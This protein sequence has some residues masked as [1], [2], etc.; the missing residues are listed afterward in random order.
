MYNTAVGAKKRQRMRTGACHDSLIYQSDN[1][2]LFQHDIV[3]GMHDLYASANAIHSELSWHNGYKIF[4]KSTIAENT[5]FDGYIKGILIV[6]NALKVP[7]FLMVGPRLIKSLNPDWI[8]PTHFHAHNGADSL[9]A[10]YNHPQDISFNDETE[11]I[12]HMAKNYDTV[13]DFCCGY[14]NILNPVIVQEKKA[15]LSDINTDCIHYIRDKYHM[16]PIQGGTN[17]TT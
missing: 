12:L 17:G 4:T 8:M 16:I 5:S 7:T 6:I 13:L 9:Y 3:T 15:I 10:V 11:A 14:G 2:I 1:A